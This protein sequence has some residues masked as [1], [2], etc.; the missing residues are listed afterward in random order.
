MLPGL[1][2]KA[3]SRRDPA[4]QVVLDAA[5]VGLGTER[6]GSQLHRLKG[7]RINQV[8]NAHVLT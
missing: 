8:R 1:V 5:T 3:E 2:L 6:P 4:F 7:R